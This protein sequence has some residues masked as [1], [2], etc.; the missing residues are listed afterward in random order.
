MT[1]FLRCHKKQLILV[2][3]LALLLVTLTSCRFDATTWYQKPYTT[4]GQEWVDLWD[5]GKGFWNALFA[6]PISIL[7]FPIAWLCSNIG[8]ALGH[9]Y[10]WGIFFT[11]LIV[12][13]V[14]WPIYSK[15]NSTSLKM[16]LMQPEMNK[17]QKKYGNR[18]DPQSQQAMQAE[19]MKLYKKYNVKPIGCIVTML[20]QFPIFMSM[21]EVVQRINKTS[22]VLV[23]G[24]T[25][26]S[27]A[28]KYAL[29]N[30]KLFN[31]FEINTSVFAAP[32][33]KD[34]I[35][36]IVIALLFGGLQILSQKL[37]QRPP[38]YQKQYPNK[39]KQE[40]QQQKSMKTMMIV[41]N[42]VF[43]FMALQSTSLAVYWFIGAIYQLFQSQVGRWLNERKYYRL[44][45]KNK[46]E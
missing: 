18:K 1:N 10:F 33:I 6:W 25:S 35:F 21:Y 31:F 11:T 26:I 38:K 22:Y 3:V 5:G 44:Q 40:S 19:M 41:M 28:G 20:L 4:Y 13:T 2:V 8:N 15:Q 14:A 12:R 30:T 17:I 43:V 39:Q 46:F 45:E 23:D 7:S 24:A 37:S 36:G 9:S 27:Y 32:E 34:K 16:Q 29:S 42:V